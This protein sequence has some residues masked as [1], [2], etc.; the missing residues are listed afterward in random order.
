MI[1]IPTIL[2]LGL[3][4]AGLALGI[5]LVRNN[6]DVSSEASS[7]SA[8]PERVVISNVSDK[9]FTVS[10][11]TKSLVVGYIS[12]GKQGQQSGE[13]LADDRDKN[14]V[15]PAQAS[16]HYVTAEGLEA[17]TAYTF[18]IGSGGGGLY[19]Q[20]G[21]PFAVKTAPALNNMPTSDV[22]QGIVFLRANKPA[23]GVVVYTQL[24]GA[25]MASALTSQTGNWIIPLSITRT[26]NGASWLQYDRSATTYGLHV[27]GG[28]DGQASATVTTAI[29]KPVPP[30]TLGQTYD[31]RKSREPEEITIAPTGSAGAE[32]PPQGDLDVSSLFNFIDLGPVTPV[33]SDVTLENPAVDGEIIQTAKPELFGKGPEGIEIEIVVQSPETVTA[34]AIVNESGAWSFAVPSDLSPGEHHITLTWTDA[35]GILQT[36]ARSFVVNASDEGTAFTS[37]PSATPTL[38]ISP[39]IIASGPT[40]APTRAPTPTTKP[41]TANVSTPSAVP[42]SGILTPSLALFIMGILLIVSGIALVRRDALYGR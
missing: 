33:S 3:I 35:Q 29:D 8:T 16:V 10:W 5:F 22:A 24:P 39:T 36:L 25:Q 21:S 9:S 34:N 28:M 41:R 14:A 15:S 6:Q 2:G 13:R 27:E 20:N 37:T 31:F 42:K 1:R 17:D 40:V 18:K 26:M 12:V 4:V 7:A 23:S 32:A 38:R 19:D 30:I 11:T